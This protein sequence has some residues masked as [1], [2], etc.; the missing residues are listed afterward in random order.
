MGVKEKS[1]GGSNAT[2]FFGALNGPTIG[3]NLFLDIISL[4]AFFYA[5]ATYFII[6]IV[7]CIKYEIIYLL[8]TKEYL[9]WMCAIAT[10][11]LL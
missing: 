8:P 3:H 9:S 5:S 1:V 11:I 4:V 10:L 7:Y 6:K 2:T